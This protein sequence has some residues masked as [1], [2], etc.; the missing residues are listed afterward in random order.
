MTLVR[1]LI[2]ACMLFLAGAVCAEDVGT[3]TLIVGSEQDY[4]PFATGDTPETA[5]GFTVE[6]WKVIA[7]DA[8]LKYTLRV[9]PF[10]QLLKEFKDG[11]SMS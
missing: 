7:H 9:K 5:D 2:V 6:L 1:L 10:H 11:K 4:P 8:G 3:R